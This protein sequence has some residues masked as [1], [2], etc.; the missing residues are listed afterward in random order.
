MNHFQDLNDDPLAEILAAPV[1][2][3]D[4]PADAPQE[5]FER[6]AKC[7]GTGVFTTYSGRVL[8]PCFACKGK[9][10]ASYRQPTAVR[11]AA[12][13][14][15]AERRQSTADANW[16]A[17]TAAHEGVA[18]WIARSAGFEFA[19][20]LGEAVRKYGSLTEKQMAAAEKCMLRDAERAQARTAERA[21]TSA[22]LDISKLDQAF[23]VARANGAVKAAIR[24]GS[25]VF[26]L[27]SATGKN[28][29]AIYC[30]TRSEGTYLGKIVGGEFKSAFACTPAHTAEIVEAAAD[31]KAAAL[32]Y[33]ALTDECSVCGRLL[34]DPDS[35]AAG[36]GPVCATKF[37][38]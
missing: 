11:A 37:G 13:A 26:S 16:A 10:G 27:A 35:K 2:R 20:S 1:E 4:I 21:A 14:A 29:G 32:R 7:R 28:P 22:K 6:C 5:H 23:S 8:G 34:T 24:T 9:G 31:P 3:R 38:W 12:R 19:K 25:I 18:A 33:A 30:K 15:S 36:I 17:F